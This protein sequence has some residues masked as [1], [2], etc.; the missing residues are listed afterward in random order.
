VVDAK[1]VKIS[2][3]KYDVKK[4]TDNRTIEKYEELTNNKS[5]LLFNLMGTG[6]GIIWLLLLVKGNPRLITIGVLS[7]L[8]ARWQYYGHM[9]GHL[10]T[11]NSEPFTAEELFT[12]V[13]LL[14]GYLT[15]GSCLLRR[16]GRSTI[17][18]A[19]MFHLWLETGYRMGYIDIERKNYD[20]LLQE[21]A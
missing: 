19:L 8:T 12:W 15:F 2:I 14:F 11:N 5:G 10:P 20:L 6:L 1:S 16:C 17:M 9:N 13:V 4:L 3:E 21:D 18:M 7:M